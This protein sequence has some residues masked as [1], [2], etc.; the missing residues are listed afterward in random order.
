[1]TKTKVYKTKVSKI[2]Q[3]PDRGRREEGS[4]AETVKSSSKNSSPRSS[5]V[6]LPTQQ[7]FNIHIDKHH[8]PKRDRKMRQ[9]LNSQFDQES[10]RTSTPPPHLG[11]SDTMY[12]TRDKV[13]VQ[14]V[15]QHSSVAG[16]SDSVSSLYSDSSIQTSDDSVF[17][18]PIKM[19]ASSRM[20]TEVGAQP[21]LRSRCLPLPR[22]DAIMP[23]YY[24]SHDELRPKYQADDYPRRRR[25]SI[26]EKRVDTSYERPMPV[27]RR[28]SE[29]T[30]PFDPRYPGPAP[31]SYNQPSPSSY[32]YKS[33][34]RQ[35]RYIE[36]GRPDPFALRAMG[37]QLDAMNYMNTQRGNA[38]PRRGILKTRENVDTDE[39]AYRPSERIQS[40]FR[41]VVA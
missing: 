6:G 13:E 32:T 37:A 24:E 12:Q 20:Q 15:S 22:N 29:I 30:N 27:I 3:S 9:R 21:R 10:R 26:Y 7:I 16:G 25:D 14:T 1:M 2:R 39:W 18:E 8:D 4:F 31:Q 5:A 19:R 36:E 17:S 11:F 35:R 23:V 40:G 28:H 34:V 33:P 38:H 41:Y